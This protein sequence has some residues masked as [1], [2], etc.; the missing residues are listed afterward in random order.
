MTSNLRIEDVSFQVATPTIPRARVTE[1]FLERGWSHSL[2][3][4]FHE[5]VIAMNSETHFLPFTIDFVSYD[6][7]RAGHMAFPGVYPLSWLP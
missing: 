7:I 3:S 2:T 5:R 6:S 4:G 1:L